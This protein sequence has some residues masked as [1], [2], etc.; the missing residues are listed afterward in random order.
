MSSQQFQQAKTQ[1][2]QLLVQPSRFENTIVYEWLGS[3]PPAPINPDPNYKGPIAVTTVQIAS[4][5][6][7]LRNGKMLAEVEMKQLHV[8][9]LPPILKIT[10]QNV[11]ILKTA[12]EI[13]EH[14]SAKQNTSNTTNAYMTSN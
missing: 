12:V 9:D 10:N 3:L 2:C 4:Y 7:Q 14:A 1:E 6:T 8:P 13:F 5:V 11:Q